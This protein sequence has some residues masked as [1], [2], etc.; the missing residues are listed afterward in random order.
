LILYSAATFEAAIRSEPRD[1][2]VAGEPPHQNV[3][4]DHTLDAKGVAFP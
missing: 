2:A 1:Q 3:G 4:R